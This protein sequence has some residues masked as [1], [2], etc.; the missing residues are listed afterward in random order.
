MKKMVKISNLDNFVIQTQ[1]EEKNEKRIIPI[2]QEID[3][4]AANLKTKGIKKKK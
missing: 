3:L 1:S 4:K 2:K